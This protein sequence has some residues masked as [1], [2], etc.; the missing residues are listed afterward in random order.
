MGLEIVSACQQASRVARRVFVPSRSHIA[1]TQVGVGIRV[2]TCRVR[3]ANVA[4]TTECRSVTIISVHGIDRVFH[5]E[6]KWFQSII[7]FK[8]EYETPGRVCVRTIG[9]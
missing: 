8:R 5:V 1:V 3:D 2:G 4:P 7:I 6:L 9:I